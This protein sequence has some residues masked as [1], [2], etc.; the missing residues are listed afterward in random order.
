[1]QSNDLTPGAQWLS[2]TDNLPVRRPNPV[3]ALRFA[4]GKMRALWHT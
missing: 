4:F 1:M 3:L 2:K